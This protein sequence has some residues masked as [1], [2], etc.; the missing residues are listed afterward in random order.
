MSNKIRID[1]FFSDLNVCARKDT[2][3]FVKKGLVVVDDVVIKK[4]DTKIDPENNVVKLNGEVINYSQYTYIMMN[5]PKGVLSATKDNTEQTVIDLIP[6]E[7]LRKGL[8]PV[9]RLDKDT[10]GLLIITNDGDFSHKIMSPK[11]HVYKI[12]QAKL[13]KEATLEDKEAFKNGLS[14]KTADFMPADLWWETEDKSL[15]HLS[16]CEGKFHQVK[17]M[18]LARGKTV[19]ELTR[20]QVG[21]LLLDFKVPTGGCRLLKKEE[22]EEIFGDI[23]K[24]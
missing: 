23:H 11:T 5:K 10:T 15:V 13:D 4:S 8:F 6:K 1:K 7:L 2:A 19:L 21:G 14:T 22:L 12:Y 16:I 9:G 20:L 18:F 17:R 24:I 3:K